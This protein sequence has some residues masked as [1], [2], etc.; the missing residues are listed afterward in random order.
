VQENFINLWGWNEY[1]GVE[2]DFGTFYEKILICGVMSLVFS[3][4][5]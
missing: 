5:V 1:M 2:A 3:H 4:S